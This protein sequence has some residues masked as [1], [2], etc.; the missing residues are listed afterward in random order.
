MWRRIVELLSLVSIPRRRRRHRDGLAPAAVGGGWPGPFR[1]DI[2]VEVTIPGARFAP[3][4]SSPRPIRA[5]PRRQHEDHKR[6]SVYQVDLPLHE[7]S[8]KW[9]GGKSVEVFDSTVVRIDTDE[10]CARAR[11]GLPARTGLPPVLRA[12]RARAGLDE[13]APQLHRRGSDPARTPEPDHGSRRS[14]GTPTSRA[15]STWPHGTCSARLAGMPACELL[16]GRYERGLRALPRHL[17]GHSRGDGRE[18]RGLPG[19]GVP[20]LPA[21]GR[22]RP[23]RRHRAGA[24]MCRGGARSEATS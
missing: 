9:S 21:Q 11:R 6:I 18:R 1:A 16:G 22:K 17:A 19:G 10:G 2:L 23:G 7:G 20:P 8:Y 14:R 4:R 15:R 13:L 3:V 12:R 24:G 5:P